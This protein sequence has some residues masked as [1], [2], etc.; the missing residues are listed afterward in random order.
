MRTT[1]GVV[2]DVRLSELDAPAA[3]RSA[4]ACRVKRAID[5]V[6]AF[7]FFPWD[8]VGENGR[9]FRGYKFRTTVS[10]AAAQ[11][12][13]LGDRNEMRDPIFKLRDDLRVTR[14]DSTP[15]RSSLDEL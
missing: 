15:R 4:G 8:V 3:L 14:F 13:D 7:L 10:G 6:G 11:P 12:A 2:A 5:V 9:L 1:G